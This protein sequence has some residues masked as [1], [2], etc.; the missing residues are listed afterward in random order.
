MNRHLFITVLNQAAVGGLFL[1]LAPVTSDLV[2]ELGVSYADVGL[3]TTTFILGQVAASLPAGYLSDRFGVKR[4]YLAANGGVIVVAALL[5]AAQSLEQILF[6]RFFLGLLMGTQFVVGS[7]YLGFW[8]PPERTSL[9]QGIYGSGFN[10]GITL[11][12]LLAAPQVSLL[13]WRG[14]Y[15]VP[16]VAT[17]VSTG[18]LW[19]MGREPSKKPAGQPTSFRLL[20]TLPLSALSLLGVGM[21]AAWGTFIVL[22][23]WLTEYLMVARE[24]AFWLS[25]VL[26]GINV[27]GSGLGRILGGVAA[28]PGREGRAVVWFYVLVTVTA[29]G[30]MAPSPLFMILALA[31]GVVTISSMGFAPILRLSIQV[32]GPGL[33]GTAV[34]YVLA[35]GM[36]IGSVL[37]TLFG[38]LVEVSGSFAV[39]F[40]V[41][42]ASP[43]AGLA[44]MLRFQ[45]RSLG[46]ERES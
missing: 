17:L 27:A 6:L 43:L 18:I 28:R 41:V 36:L 10:F 2:R 29:A 31:F 23:A 7:S 34:G 19:T 39:G 15:L 40:S 16:G 30:L 8:S 38:W 11:S 20:R 35:L 3:V 32:S 42:L 44:A 22:G 14:V 5:A 45:L 1:N 26:T 13:G 25:A 9:Y 33:Q 46:A 37:P 4:I 24:S 12:F 21:G